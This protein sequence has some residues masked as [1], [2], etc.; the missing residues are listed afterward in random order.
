MPEPYLILITVY[1]RIID[2]YLVK[3]FDGPFLFSIFT[4][5]ALYI[6]IDLFNLLEDILKYHINWDVLL[7]YYLN[8]APSIYVQVCPIATLIAIMFGLGTLNRH[9]EITAMKA[10][11]VNLFRIAK[12][13]LSL[14]IL[15]SLFTILINEKI[16]PATSSTSI[17]IFII[18]YMIKHKI[19]NDVKRFIV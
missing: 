4:F 11:G 3:K 2:R 16:V 9:F 7:R 6:I 17:D 18:S 10:G 1:M 15:I 8:M 5:L 13:Y 19:N 14:G 12:P